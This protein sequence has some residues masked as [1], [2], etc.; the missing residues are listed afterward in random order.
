MELWNGMVKGYD[1]LGDYK[2]TYKA[3]IVREGNVLYTMKL[4]FCSVSGNRN[5][6]SDR[7]LKEKLAHSSSIHVLKRKFKNSISLKTKAKI[8]W[9]NLCKKEDTVKLK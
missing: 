9:I 4:S 6:Q 5:T 8:T 3:T 1:E 2:G 7:Y